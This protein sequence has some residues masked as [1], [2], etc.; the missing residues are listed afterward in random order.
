MRNTLKFKARTDRPLTDGRLPVVAQMF[1]QGDKLV[2]GLEMHV[3]RQAFDQKRG[4]VKP[5]NGLTER[6]AEDMNMELDRFR[7]KFNTI[8]Y[9]HRLRDAP[10]SRDSMRQQLRQEHKG[11]CFHAWAEDRIQRLTPERAPGTIKQYKVTFRALRE[12]M[13]RMTFSELTPALPAK[14]ESWLIR[15]GLGGNARSKYHKHLKSF[16]RELS[17]EVPVPDVY[18]RFRISQT[19]GHRAY[20]LSVDVQR[21]TALFDSGELTDAYRNALGMFLFSCHT[22]LRF[23]DLILIEHANIHGRFLSFRPEKTKRLNKWVDVPL[24]D[25]ARRFI[26]TRSG[27]MFHHVSNQHYG[28]MLKELAEAAGVDRRISAHSGR[29]TFGTGYISSGGKVTVLQRIMGHAKLDTTMI[30]VHMSRIHLEE[31]RHIVEQL[32]RGGEG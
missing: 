13:P 15:R 17:H 18:A 5:T 26:T 16:T 32:H 9:D 12:F 23:G 22:G 6:E 24:S 10:L 27:R 20:L 3:P 21:L 8:I 28:R 30:Y 7:Q 25:E 2:L 31:E 11:N 29:H 4:R 14:L 1:I 19:P